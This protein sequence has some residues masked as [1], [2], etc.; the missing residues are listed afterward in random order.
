MY[1]TELLC[2]FLTNSIKEQ[3]K[4]AGAQSPAEKSNTDTN[5]ILILFKALTLLFILFFI[6][7][8]FIKFIKAFIK[9]P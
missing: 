4:F 7:N 9:L 2:Y 8:L 5:K 3:D 1:L 6:K